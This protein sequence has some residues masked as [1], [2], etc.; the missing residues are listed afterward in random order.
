MPRY[1]VA[2]SEVPGHPRENLGSWLRGELADAGF[3][4]IAELDYRRAEWEH[5]F[6]APETSPF[7][8]ILYGYDAENEARAIAEAREVVGDAFHV[9]VVPVRVSPAGA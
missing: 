3:E 5:D 9:K 2:I 7:C 6:P 1:I 8:R 4:Q